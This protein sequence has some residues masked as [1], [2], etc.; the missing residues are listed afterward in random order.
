M[1]HKVC[2]VGRSQSRDSEGMFPNLLSL[3]HIVNSA[4]GLI[5]LKCIHTGLQE[6]P[7]PQTLRCL[8]VAILPS[9]ARV[10]PALRCVMECSR[11]PTPTLPF[12]FCLPLFCSWGQKPLLCVFLSPVTRTVHMLG[13]CGMSGGLVLYEDK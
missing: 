10:I 2:Y 3:Q 5:S 12:S 4:A 9:F 11:F 7:C 13:N 8:R 6:P 1:R